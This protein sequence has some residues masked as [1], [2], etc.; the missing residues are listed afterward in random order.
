MNMKEPIELLIDW[1]KKNRVTESDTH[2]SFREN[3]K[4]KRDNGD[5]WEIEISLGNVV[6]LFHVYSTGDV[7][8]NNRYLDWRLILFEEC[9]HANQDE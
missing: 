5:N 8:D 3:H 6:Y 1:M 9:V 7:K 2:D 4:I